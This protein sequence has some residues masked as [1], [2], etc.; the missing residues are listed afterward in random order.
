M[1]GADRLALGIDP[2]SPLSVADIVECARLAETKGFAATWVA[3]GRRGDVFALLA[4]LAM[5]T[6]TIRLGAGVIPVSVRSPWAV[7]MGASTVD[8]ISGHRFML[9]L[10]AGHKSVIENRHGLAYDRPT[11]RM[12]EVTEIVRRAL[13]G[14][15]VNFQGDIFQLNRAQL[16]VRPAQC[17]VPVYIAGIGPRVLQLA[18]EIADG[19]FLIFPTAK[20]LRTSLSEI[21]HGAA[22]AN[23]DVGNFDVV[24]YIF[25]CIAADRRAAVATSRRTIAYYGRLPHYRGLFAQ[26]GFSKETEMLKDAWANND[27]G[28][29]TRTISDGMVFALSATGTPDDVAARINT[30]IEAGL[31]QAVLFPLAVNGDAKGAILQTIEAL[32]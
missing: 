3:E 2:N 7:A 6:S 8:E 18:G 14:E 29:A 21:S 27:A 26:E 5:S 15:E 10:G 30:L 31:K 4:A 25:T 19:A 24:A 9:G 20:S 22:R 32:S 12:R 11:L 28:R 17:D 13:T 23:R 16:S 1:I